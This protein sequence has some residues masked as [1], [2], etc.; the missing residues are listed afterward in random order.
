MSGIEFTINF[1]DITLNETDG[2]FKETTELMQK[3]SPRNKTWVL[4][5][6]ISICSVGGQGSMEVQFHADG[7]LFILHYSPSVADLFYNPDIQV[8]AEWS[9]ENG[10]K[11][12]KPHPDLVKDNKEFWKHFYDTLV[13]DSDYLDELYGKRPQLEG[14]KE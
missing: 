10:W 1:T 3:D 7:N 2:D 9:Q 5:S 4:R 12:P 8:L 11:R 14:E 13:I 6:F